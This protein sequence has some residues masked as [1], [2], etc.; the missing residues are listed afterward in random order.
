MTV[1]TAENT[2]QLGIDTYTEARDSTNIGRA[3]LRLVESKEASSVYRVDQEPTDL[4]R[5]LYEVVVEDKEAAGN[6]DSFSVVRIDQGS[7][8]GDIARYVEAKIFRE[9]WY[10]N[11]T[12][13]Q[14]AEEMLTEY[15]PYDDKSRFLLVMDTETIDEKGL[16]KLV[17]MARVVGEDVNLLKT[18]H[19]M[20]EVWGISRE[21]ILEDLP[22]CIEGNEALC[23]DQIVGT[24]EKTWDYSSMA[25][26]E[27][28][29]GSNAYPI[30]SGE[31][32]KWSLEHDITTV[33]TIF[34][35]HFYKLYR[36]RGV[37]F[38]AICD[39]QPQVHMGALSIPAIW[40]IPETKA[41][42]NG[43]HRAQEAYHQMVEGEGLS[44]HQFS[45]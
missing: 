29:R 16:P 9:S 7:K 26:S 24:P 12:P 6:S 42:L 4:I 44:Y 11:L 43:N 5:E 8:F 10:Q 3:A 14:F 18:V 21:V 45:I 40:H 28:Y 20:Q 13:E 30:I 34:V 41:M 15:S 25:V 37:P 36:L 17:G 2:P 19:D 27:D 32:Y 33:T 31:L 35:E 1:N 38:R 39:V 22:H 23:A